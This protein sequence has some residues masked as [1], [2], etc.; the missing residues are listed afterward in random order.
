MQEETRTKKPLK[1]SA[2]YSKWKADDNNSD[3]KTRRQ[4]FRS[5]IFTKGGESFSQALAEFS[6][7]ADSQGS[8]STEE[9]RDMAD[10]YINVITGRFLSALSKL[11][12]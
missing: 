8:N 5:S 11:W 2:H 7:L 4:V 9:A 1:T 12:R 3:G 10:D 6:S